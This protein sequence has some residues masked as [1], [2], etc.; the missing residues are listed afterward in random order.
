LSI[1]FVL[2]CWGQFVGVPVEGGCAVPARLW[3]RRES[4]CKGKE[5]GEG[6]GQEKWG[7]FA[8]FGQKESRCYPSRTAAA[9]KLITKTN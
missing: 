5:R 2:C 4:D 7:V 3:V 8:N 6:R 1:V 9:K